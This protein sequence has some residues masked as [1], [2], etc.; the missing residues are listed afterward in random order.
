[1]R[2]IAGGNIGIGTTAPNTILDV[3]G[4][5][6]MREISAPSV[7]PSDQG[8]IYFDNTDNKFKVSENGGAYVD[9]IGGGGGGGDFANVGEAGTADRTLGNTDNFDLGLLTNNLT[10]LHI[11]NDGN[12]GVG[13]NTTPGE[14]LDAT[15][16]VN[17][18]G[19]YRIGGSTV[20]ETSA[21]LQNTFVGIGAGVNNVGGNDN[22]FVGYGAGENNTGGTDN[23]F[24]GYN[25]GNASSSTRN[26]FMGYAT[27]DANTS[28]ANNVYIGYNAAD[29][30]TSGEQ[31]VVIG[32][33]AGGGNTSYSVIIG[34]NAGNVSNGSQNVFVG[35]EAGQENTSG[36]ANIFIGDEAGNSNLSGNL[37]TFV[38][39]NS[40]RRSTSGTSNVY[41]GERAGEDNN[42]SNNVFI[43]PDA[44]ANETNTS[45]SLFIDNSNTSLPLVHGNFSSDIFTVNGQLDVVAK[46]SD[47][48]ALYASI[49]NVSQGG[50]LAVFDRITNFAADGNYYDIVF[51]HGNDADQQEDFAVMRMTATDVSDGTEGGSLSFLVA[52]G[53]LSGADP[54]EV[55][56]LNS[57]TT[58]T[59]Q[60]SIIFD[61]P[62]P[63]EG[64]LT[65]TVDGSDDDTLIMSSAGGIG[66]TRGAFIQLAG[67]E[68]SAGNEG[69]LYL[70]A[71]DDS[72]GGEI[73]FETGSTERMRIEQNGNVGIGTSDPQSALHV[74]DNSY[75]QFEDN[76]AGAPPAGDCDADTERGRMSIDITNN[77][78]YICNGATRGWDYIL[79]ID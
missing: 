14:A 23:T 26:V 34:H 39:Y 7:S 51:R 56:T 42:G 72:A 59:F 22:T 69:V 55:M 46:T 57:D 65:N 75:A 71:G 16:N 41:V 66:P 28:G 48:Q 2:I 35:H 76:N 18:S 50:D 30:S 12:I 36:V 49:N 38:G 33:D 52:N 6:S 20:L 73:R 61:N 70:A 78:L 79:M 13:G 15:G 47:P 62:A 63:T 9:L 64:I 67:N 29:T 54:V 40:G 21:I 4:A 31:N 44:G 1:M 8:R 43:G 32:S 27:G 68:A 58:T 17:V 11:Q 5:M 24:V 60:S 77:R 19:D 3:N 10:R 74:P 53:T 45:N 37:N 25:A